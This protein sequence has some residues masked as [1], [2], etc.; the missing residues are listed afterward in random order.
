[1]KPSVSN[2]KIVVA[3]D[4]GCLSGAQ[5]Q[6]IRGG[7]GGG[8]ETPWGVFGY[9]ER[10][11][12]RGRR[13]GTLAVRVS[14]V[15]E[16]VTTGRGSDNERWLA[17]GRRAFRRSHLRVDKDHD[18]WCSSRWIS[19]TK[20]GFSLFSISLYWLLSSDLARDASIKNQ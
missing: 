19:S 6:G 13:W 16:Q 9:Q 20:T 17:Y 15:S 2:L 1:M 8:H 7:G 11:A 12:V 18:G 14:I 10:A 5:Q 4:R 3:S